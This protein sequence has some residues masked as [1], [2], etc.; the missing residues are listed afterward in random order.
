MVIYA[1]DCY[2]DLTRVAT[3]CFFSPLPGM[4][5]KD[6]MASAHEAHKGSGGAT[7]K[8]R[9]DG[10]TDVTLSDGSFSD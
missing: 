8:G 7:K 9:D 5:S 2:E 6:A 4:S 10:D 3:V 1:H